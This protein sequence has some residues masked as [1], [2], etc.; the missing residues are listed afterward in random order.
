MCGETGSVVHDG[1]RT[2]GLSPRVRGNQPRGSGAESLLRSIP[3][4]A[5]KPSFLMLRSICFRVY[6]RVCGETAFGAFFTASWSGL[7]PRV[8]GNRSDAGQRSP[9]SRSIPAC[10]GKPLQAGAIGSLG[11]VY[12]RVCGETT[13]AQ[14]KNWPN[15]GLSPRVRGNHRSHQLAGRDGGSIPA[16][17]GKP[18]EKKKRVYIARVYP[19]VCGE[20]MPLR[21]ASS[22]I[23]GLSPR[24][25]GNHGPSSGTRSQQGSIPACAGKP[26][27]RKRRRETPGVYPR[28]CGETR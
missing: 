11:K 10:A 19:R 17:A 27:M 3:A 5:G 6:P 18:E 22:S 16:C 20:T 12:P 24:V 9:R 23:Q 14:A 8:R 25:R 13:T 28:V 15:T 26:S 21:F 7:S 4:C 1:P 2:L